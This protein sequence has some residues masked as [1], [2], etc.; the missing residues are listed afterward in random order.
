MYCIFSVASFFY[1]FYE[2]GL[3]GYLYRRY[4]PQVA[5]PPP[6]AVAGND[7]GGAEIQAGVPGRQGPMQEQQEQGWSVGRLLHMLQTPPV[8]PRGTGPAKDVLALLLAFFCS[9]FPT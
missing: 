4:C 8:V 2:V 1:Y 9:L 3:W 7:A 6:P 5:T